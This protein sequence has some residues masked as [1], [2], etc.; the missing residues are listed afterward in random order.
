MGKLIVIY[1]INNLGKTTQA[2]RLVERLTVGGHTASYL[3]YPLYDL[4][5]S[6]PLINEYLRKNNPHNFT[7]REFQ[8]LQV[9]NR[10]Q[11]DAELRQRLAAGE[12][13][14][15]EDYVGTG[16]AWGMGA[17]VDRLLLERLNSHLYAEDKAFLF[18]GKRFVEATEVGHRHETDNEL[19]E[20]VQGA[21]NELGG[22]Y[23]W[24][25][26]NANLS[27]EEIT[28]ELWR[29]VEEIFSV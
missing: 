28:D 23:H 10:S 13:I 26:I 6:G 14:V 3:K 8:L 5:P 15:A 29:I 18:E 7:P 16:I 2:R 17:G 27:I 11:Y 25:R 1:G 4:E 22:D 20:A 19:M 21:H 9:K 24:H 12:W